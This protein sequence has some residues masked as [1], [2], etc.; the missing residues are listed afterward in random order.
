[1]QWNAE[2]SKCRLGPVRNTGLHHCTEL[3]LICENGGMHH[4]GYTEGVD[5]L[6]VAGDVGELIEWFRWFVCSWVGMGITVG[7]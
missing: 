5:D 7:L 6:L 2:S 1:M 4:D 3:H